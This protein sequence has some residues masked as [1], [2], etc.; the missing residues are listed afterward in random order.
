MLFPCV[1]L[2][3]LFECI[4]N[5]EI[6]GRSVWGEQGRQN[7]WPI[8]CAV[9]GLC[10]EPMKGI[11]AKFV[12]VAQIHAPASHSGTTPNAHTSALVS[13]S[14]NSGRRFKSS[15]VRRH[16]YVSDK[17]RD[18]CDK[19]RGTFGIANDRHHCSRE[20]ESLRVCKPSVQTRM[21][22]I[23]EC[24][25]THPALPVQMLRRLI[26]CGTLHCSMRYDSLWQL[27][28]CAEMNAP[29]ASRRQSYRNQ[30]A[31]NPICSVGS[32]LLLSIFCGSPRLTAL[33]A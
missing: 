16:Y 8:G 25:G 31:Q 1:M 32:R 2:N 29:I 11:F 26:D 23:Q 19:R 33:V 17:F 6:R 5:F 18:V 24:D 10:D 13:T 14:G 15:R 22:P 27:S 28:Y 20:K 12:G 4:G 30:H 3:V 9:R 7:R 21:P